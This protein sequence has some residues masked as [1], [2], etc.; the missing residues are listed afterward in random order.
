MHCF[1]AAQCAIRFLSRKACLVK[2]PGQVFDH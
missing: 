1:L 2:I